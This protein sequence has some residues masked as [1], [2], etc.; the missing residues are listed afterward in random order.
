V[1]VFSQGSDPPINGT[2]SMEEDAIPSEDFLRRKHSLLL[3]ISKRTVDIFVSLFFFLIF[4]WLYA[5]IWV[6]VLVTS[7]SPVMYSQQRFGKT[8][9]VFKFYKFR[10]MVPDAAQVLE[11][12]LKINIEARQQWTDFQKLENDPRITWFG[13]FIR[14]TSLDE[15]PQFW[16][17]L[18]GDMS[19]VG[20]RPCMLSQQK[21]YGPY[22]K[23]YC[24][25]RPGITG[26]WQVSGRNNLSFE[27]RVLLDAEYVETLSVWK[28]VSIFLRTLWVVLSGHG[29]R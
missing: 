25:V 9:K 15:L 3:R 12:H 18:R 20:P 5:L 29:S 14:K 6:G 27:K 11:E 13:A 19:F 17:V 22:W 26:L 7:G 10:S 2:S 16:N 24:V 4:G 21:L 23:H 28:D 8:G 1:N